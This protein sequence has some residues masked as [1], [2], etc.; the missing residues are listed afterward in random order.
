MHVGWTSKLIVLGSLFATLALSSF[1]RANPLSCVGVLRGES[2]EAIAIGSHRVQPVLNAL[3]TKRAMLEVINGAKTTLQ[4]TSDAITEK[5]YIEALSK[6]SKRGVKVQ[7][8][9]SHPG[10]APAKLQNTENIQILNFPNRW[11]QFGTPQPF[12]EYHGKLL[13][14]DEKKVYIGDSNLSYFKENIGA[15]ALIEGPAV[16]DLV[17]SFFRAWSEA[18]GKFKTDLTFPDKQDSDL[19]VLMTRYGDLNIKNAI[20]KDLNQAKASIFLVQHL[21]N[22]PDILMSLMRLKAEKPKLQIQVLLGKKKSILEV[23]G[24]EILYPFNLYAYRELR[25]AGVDARFA[26]ED[27]FIFAKL[28][29]VDN[30]ISHLGSA[31]LSARSLEGNLETN[32]RIHSAQL[33]SKVRTE[34]QPL[35]DQ[36][37]VS[38][39]STKDRFAI[40]FANFMTDTST[41]AFNKAH[42][43]FHASRALTFN[44]VI[45]KKFGRVAYQFVDRIFKPEKYAPVELKPYRRYETLKESVLKDFN[46]FSTKELAKRTE[47]VY[48]IAGHTSER[49]EIINQL[50]VQPAFN[51]DIGPGLYLTNDPWIAHEYAY[52]HGEKGSLG[53]VIYEAQ[54]KN[55]FRIPR[56]KQEFQDWLKNHESEVPRNPWQLLPEFCL[57]KGYDSAIMEHFEGEGRSYFLIFDREKVR[58]VE[59]LIV[60]PNRK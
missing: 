41:W 16:L 14:A 22:D 46:L 56:Q 60:T 45:A 9:L 6:A 43:I 48:L 59:S 38:E 2:S 36:A 57:E 5:E 30:E 1:A 44:K 58:A 18:G 35:Y 50:G 40:D 39:V 32:V 31:D 54:I 25:A 19:K 15:G 26:K 51:G 23:L 53:L 28:L 3:A 13:I 12:P 24:K 27:N 33:A 34:L 49:T 11:L 21:L 42:R 7:I 29:I 10:A 55:P 8:V 37:E 47:G 17:R 4:V 20:L 52:I